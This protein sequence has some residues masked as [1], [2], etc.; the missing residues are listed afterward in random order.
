MLWRALSKKAEHCRDIDKNEKIKR[1]WEERSRSTKNQK[2]YRKG[3]AATKKWMDINDSSQLVLMTTSAQPK[4]QTHSTC[5]NGGMTPIKVANLFT[6]TPFCLP[7]SS[8][9]FRLALT[10][11]CLYLHIVL[12]FNTQPHNMFLS[13]HSICAI[14][15]SGSTGCI[16]IHIKNIWKEPFIIVIN[17]SRKNLMRKDLNCSI[18]LSQ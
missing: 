16:T 3:T 4:H 2:W 7:P 8:S 1:I 5:P 10:S 15:C 14:S 9:Q 12:W 18:F 11:K 17:R 6:L 13:Q